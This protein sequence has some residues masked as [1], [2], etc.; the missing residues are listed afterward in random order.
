MSQNPLKMRGLAFVELTGDPA[1]LGDLLERLG[2]SATRKDPS[3]A[4]TLYEQGETT[5]VVSDEPGSFAA[6]FRAAHGPAACAV[7]FLVD[8]AS[9]AF[10]EAVAR[11]ATPYE[12]DAASATLTFAAP[13]IYGVGKTLVYFVEGAPATRRGSAVERACRVSANA[14]PVPALGLGRIDHLTNNVERGQLAATAKFYEDVFGFTQ[15]RS[16][17]IV[18]AK[19]G[20]YSF[21]L[22]SPCGTFCIPINEDKGNKG[23]IAEYLVEHRGPGIQHIALTTN[24]LLAT[25]DRLGGRVPTLDLDATYY[26]NCFSR[27]PGV[28]ED[29]KR[30]EAHNVLVDGD[31]EGYLLQI[32]TKNCIGPAF[33]ELIQRENHHSFGEGNFGALFRSLERDQERRGVL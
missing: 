20:L 28:R 24:D 14:T 29:P 5:F 25:L 4:S 3:C 17:D 1:A 2:F 27:V 11:G 21:A 10:A 16:F 22:R 33:F 9:K 12:G 26:E 31:D 23:Q 13:A 7:G 6:A 8:D 18:G 15:V 30:I 32:F 19:S